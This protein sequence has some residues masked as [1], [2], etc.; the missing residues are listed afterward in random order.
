MYNPRYET[1]VPYSDGSLD[2]FWREATQDEIRISNLYRKN[3]HA[4]FYGTPPFV[5]PVE[6]PYGYVHED[7]IG[8]HRTVRVHSKLRQYRRDGLYRDDR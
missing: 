1:W 2:G 5:D 3:E 4:G 6:G 7:W 8:G